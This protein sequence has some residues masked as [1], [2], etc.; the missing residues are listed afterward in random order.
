MATVCDAAGETTFGPAAAKRMKVLPPGA[1]PPPANGEK[2]PATGSN[3][4]AGALTKAANRSIRR[5]EGRDGRHREHRDLPR[6]VHRRCRR[7]LLGRTDTG[8][9]EDADGH[10][11]HDRRAGAPPIRPAMFGHRDS[12]A[13]LP[14]STGSTLP[15]VGALATR[16][17]LLGFWSGRAPHYLVLPLGEAPLNCRTKADSSD[18]DDTPAFALAW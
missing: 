4:L 7:R 8:R 14:V 10:G 12:F 15:H 1:T 16:G 11:C 3:P 5:G 17:R 18:R 2:P 13:P 9:N 6:R